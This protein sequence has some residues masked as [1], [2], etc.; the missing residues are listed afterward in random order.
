[1]W[2]YPVDMKRA[3]E[4]G[5]TFEKEEKEEIT[6]S[7]NEKDDETSDQKDDEGSEEISLL[8]RTKARKRTIKA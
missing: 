2:I 7:E 8:N 5:Q 3:N 1:M 6:K 4:F